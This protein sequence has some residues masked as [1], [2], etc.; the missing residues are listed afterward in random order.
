MSSTPMNSGKALRWH[1]GVFLIL[2]RL[3]K[4]AQPRASFDCAR[5]ATETERA[6]CG[7]VSLAAFDASVAGSYKH[8]LDYYDYALRTY[9]PRIKPQTV[10][11]L[12]ALQAVPEGLAQEARC[13]RERRRLPRTGHG[14]AHPGDGP[15]DRQLRLRQPQ[16][17]S[18][19][20]GGELRQA[21][22]SA[23]VVTGG[24]KRSMPS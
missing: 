18:P 14:R 1:E 15:G 7:S 6:I 23:P 13:L 11:Q 12:A 8:A 16:L 9:D 20:H 17:R 22:R 10:K 4:D 5:A 21:L 2:K 3:P 24:A 19:P